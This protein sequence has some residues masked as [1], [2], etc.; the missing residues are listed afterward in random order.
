MFNDVAGVNTVKRIIRRRNPA[1]RVVNQ[2]AVIVEVVAMET[3]L[4]VRP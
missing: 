1:A 2:N 4:Q 3:M